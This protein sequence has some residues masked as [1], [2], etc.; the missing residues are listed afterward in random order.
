MSRGQFAL[1]WKALYYSRV[2][3]RSQLWKVLLGVVVMAVGA[4]ISIPLGRY[5]EQDDAPGGVV[6]ALLIFA[7]AAVLASWI[8]WPRTESS[9]GKR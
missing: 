7:G 9:A 8:A 4:A 3:S 6:I 5:A 2:V 1:Y